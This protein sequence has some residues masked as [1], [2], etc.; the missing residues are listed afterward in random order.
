MLKSID[1]HFRCI[2]RSFESNSL[3]SL[4]GS[5]ML[6]ISIF[7]AFLFSIGTV[8]GLA[9]DIDGGFFICRVLCK[10][11]DCRIIKDQLG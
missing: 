7:F 1:F 3:L 8:L 11:N 5:Y 2:F 4:Y 6:L 9:W 10:G